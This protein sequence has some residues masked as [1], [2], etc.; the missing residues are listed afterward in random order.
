MILKTLRILLAFSCCLLS[1][2][3]LAQE[4]NSESKLMNGAVTEDI[5][6]DNVIPELGVEL[7]DNTQQ[8]TIVKNVIEQGSQMKDS[9]QQELAQESSGSQILKNDNPKVGSHV[10]ANMDAGSMILSLLMV[11]ALIIICA[12][13]LKRFN[14]T[15]QG[16]SQLKVVTSLSL[17][18]KER[19][20][21][22]QAGEQQL[23]LGVTAQQVTL[24]ERLEEPLAPQTMKAT[25][26]PKSLMSFLSAKKA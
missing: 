1:T 3:V 21:V 17:G 22:I 8:S 2:M 26:L 24:I 11:L 15:Q 6:N 18:A 9:V 7:Q 5:V 23:L 13:V 20:V 14:L 19:V 10:M 12:F 4:N 25:E 16:V